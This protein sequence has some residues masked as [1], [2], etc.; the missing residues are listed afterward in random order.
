MLSIRADIFAVP[1][2]HGLP[3]YL[4][5]FEEEPGTEKYLTDIG[6]IPLVYITVKQDGCPD[7]LTS[8]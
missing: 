2:S 8:K 7:I 6:I 5:Q 1:F 4:S 3:C